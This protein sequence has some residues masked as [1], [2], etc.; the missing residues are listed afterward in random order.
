MIS[1]GVLEAGVSDRQR[2]FEAAVRQHSGGLFAMAY[3]ILRDRHAA[4]DAVQETAEQAWR[5]WDSLR[6]PGRR[7]AWM[8]QICVRRCLR[9]RRGA[10]LADDLEAAV[11]P[12]PEVARDLAIDAAFQRLSP[13]QRAVV[14][15]HYRHGY[16]LDECAE[17]MGCA[18]GTARSHLARALASLRKELSDD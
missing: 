10:R 4:D 9:Q 18:P 16:G 5:G 14:A 2:D 15:L 1:M 11:S 12:F 17:L 7:G 8:R 6:D 3:S 13:K